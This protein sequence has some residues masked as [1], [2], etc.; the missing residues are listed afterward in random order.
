MESST[1]AVVTA[2]FVVMAIVA[3]VVI[4]VVFRAMWAIISTP[5]RP[6]D[7]AMTAEEEGNVHS[8]PHGYTGGAYPE[9]QYGSGFDPDAD[10]NR[11]H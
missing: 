10:W 2:I 8:G 11:E 3:L 6:A 7:P 4:V 9:S 5:A 1:S